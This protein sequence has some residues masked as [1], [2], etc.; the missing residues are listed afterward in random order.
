MIL[1]SRRGTRHR[2]EPLAERGNQGSGADKPRGLFT[3]E[4]TSSQISR[5]W[6]WWWWFI[7]RTTHLVSLLC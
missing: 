7:P 3:G 5:W 1:V 2:V 6:W 4:G